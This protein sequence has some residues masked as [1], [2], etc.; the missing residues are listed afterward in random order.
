MNI[1]KSFSRLSNWLFQWRGASDYKRVISTTKSLKT[2]LARLFIPAKK[3]EQSEEFAAAVAR[4]GLS[5]EELA[6]KKKGFLYLALMCLGLALIIFSY[7]LYLLLQSHWRGGAVAVVVCLLV[8]TLAF[9]Y[10]F[11][12]FQLKQC[13]LGCTLKEWLTEGL[14][15]RFI[16]KKT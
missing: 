10:H 2:T 7:A 9:R 8:T 3:P 11:W 1:S 4:L 14:L 5:A 13:K 15:K 16:G 6:K 12:Y